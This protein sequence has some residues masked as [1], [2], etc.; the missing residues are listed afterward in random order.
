MLGILEMPSK[1]PWVVVADA[2]ALDDA[3]AFLDGM[4][5]Y[6]LEKSHFVSCTLC[7]VAFPH[8][9]KYQLACCDSDTCLRGDQD[10]GWRAKVLTC[11]STNCVT[12]ATVGEH[13]SGIA[14]PKTG[15]LNNQ[16]R[17]FCQ[18]MAM[19]GLR[20]VRIRNSIR[21]KFTLGTDAMPSLRVIQNFVNYYSR[22]HMDH[23]D[24][25]EDIR[26]LI[27]KQSFSG[28][29]E[30]ATPF[31]F[32]WDY[33]SDG[34]PVVGDGSDGDP[35]IVG[36]SSKAM[37]KRLA[38][39]PESFILHL[40]ATFKLN[41]VD[42]PVVVVGVSDRC[43]SFHVVALF[44]V[45]QRV[46]EI[47]AKILRSMCRIY[48]AVTGSRLCI[49]YVMGDA[50]QSQR[51][52]VEA[53]FASS[54]ITYLM[55]F[56]HV[57]V[58]VQKKLK[59][60]MHKEA[61][62]GHLY[63]LH[64]ARTEEE[65]TKGRD[66]CLALWRAHE[67]LT[68]FADYCDAQWLRGHFSKWQC[69]HTP[70]AFA[71]TNNPVEQYNRAIKRDYTLRRRLKMGTLLRQLFACVANESTTPRA[72]RDEI[73]PPASLLRRA[74]EMANDGYL[75]ESPRAAAAL[76]PAMLFGLR[77]LVQSVAVDR[78]WVPSQRRTKE[79][80]PV[81]AQMGKNYGRMEVEGQ[82]P[83]GWLVDIAQRWCACRFWFKFGTCIHLLHALSISDRM[84][85]SGK[86][87]LVN[88]NA[89]KKA[90]KRG[91]PRTNGPALSIE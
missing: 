50:E 11:E 76:G 59:D 75:N 80:L 90:A 39:P 10:C 77:T 71:T 64:F 28:S 58:N 8:N 65:Y 17:L 56:F 24:N 87:M 88:R 69:Y 4:K 72:F 68:A 34:K 82:P 83:D 27:Q 91:R 60:S 51:N 78:T 54:G 89:S 43:R 84:T 47:Y 7:Q 61:V 73:E 21:R 41:Q 26:E 36:M 14:S 35:F 33:D 23:T 13:V 22:K 45:S 9:M 70:P 5:T 25:Y 67:S 48:A 38:R 42:Y 57:M 46:E 62:I 32:A 44:V 29:E 66:E 12:I 2:L 49:R 52:A 15:A 1:L 55:C 31:T 3:M 18:E 30:S 86:R 79:C 85:P 74:K 53:V 6:K 16:Q 37:M 63:N 20:P 40:D 81:T 19:E